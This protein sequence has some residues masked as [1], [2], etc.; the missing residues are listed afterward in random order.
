MY[1]DCE[2]GGPVYNLDASLVPTCAQ[3]LR[4]GRLRHVEVDVGLPVS[5]T[6]TCLV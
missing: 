2:A 5:L 1:A 6:R 4:T 3:R